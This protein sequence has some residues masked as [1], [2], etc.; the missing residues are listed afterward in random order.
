MCFINLPVSI[1]IVKIVQ[2]CLTA[3]MRQLR[4]GIGR[5]G[6]AGRDGSLLSIIV[7][8]HLPGLSHASATKCGYRVAS[9]SYIYSP[10][11]REHG[12]IENKISRC[13]FKA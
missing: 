3:G 12:T 8:W 9:H 7:V 13:F 6:G 4:Q 10:I 1:S 11:R 5:V 2:K